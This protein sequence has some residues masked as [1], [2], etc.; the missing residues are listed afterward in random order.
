MRRKEQWH[1]GSSVYVPYK[2]NPC[3]TQI[4]LKFPIFFI[5]FNLIIMWYVCISCFARADNCK[6]VFIQIM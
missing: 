5:T 6:D 1:S 4:P 3:F 2:S